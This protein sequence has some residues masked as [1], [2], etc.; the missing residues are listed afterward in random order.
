MFVLRKE[1]EQVTVTRVMNPKRTESLLHKPM[2]TSLV[3]FT[4]GED[5]LSLRLSEYY[6]NHLLKTEKQQG[7]RKTTKMTRLSHI[8]LSFKTHS[9]MKGVICLVGVDVRCGFPK[10]EALTTAFRYRC[11]QL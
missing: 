1:L 7:I 4:G 6:R 2:V 11:A 5:E 3:W 8:P 10:E 9:I